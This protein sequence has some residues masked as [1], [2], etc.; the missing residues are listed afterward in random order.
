MKKLCFPIGTV[1]F[2]AVSLLL[3][4]VAN[5][6]ETQPFSARVMVD[7]TAPQNIKGT[8]TSYINRELRDIGDIEIVDDNEEWLLEIIV[9]EFNTIS[10][11]KI[12]YTF[13][14]VILQKFN[15]LYL[16][17]LI[18]EM[19]EEHVKMLT[20]NLYYCPRHSL[21]TSSTEDVRTT[22]NGIVAEFDTECLEAKR[23]LYRVMREN[24]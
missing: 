2:I 16:E 21:Q 4:S 10:G 18:Q 19:W 23:K 14:T 12:G 17:R 13:S 20:S 6:Q 11:S 8:V 24:K 15:N 9:L 22:C 5:P 1:F 3:N 7:I